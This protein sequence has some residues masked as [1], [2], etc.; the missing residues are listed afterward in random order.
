MNIKLNR[1]NVNKKNKD[2]PN[3]PSQYVVIPMWILEDMVYNH[4]SSIIKSFVLLVARYTLGMKSECCFYSTRRLAEMMK[5]SRQRIQKA[6]K[7][8][9]RLGYIAED[10]ISIPEITSLDDGTKAYRLNFLQPRNW[11]PP[12]APGTFFEAFNLTRNIE[13]IKLRLCERKHEDNPDIPYLIGKIK[14]YMAGRI[15]KKD[16]DDI[17]S[18]FDK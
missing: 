1:V 6:I 16:F 10:M 12:E 9:R 11:K 17:I 5:F 8:C 2:L 14:S 4:R 3:F 18:M 7:E 15:T 13:D